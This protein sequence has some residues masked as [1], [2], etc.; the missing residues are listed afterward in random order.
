MLIAIGRMTAIDTQDTATPT[1]EPPRA[2]GKL[3]DAFHSNF[4]STDPKP[5]T[6]AA[7]SA[8]W[9]GEFVSA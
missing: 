7:S 6:T 4:V 8:L 5:K 1:P 9:E 3:R 2:A